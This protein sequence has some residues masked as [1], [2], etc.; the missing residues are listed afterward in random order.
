MA[1]DFETE[2]EFQEQLDWIDDFVREE[3]EPLDLV[4]GGLEFTPLEEPLRSIVDPLKQQVR[5]RGLWACHLGPELG[6]QG[7]RP[8]EAVADERD[9]R[10]V[11]VGPD[12]VRHA[13]H[14]TPATPRSSPTTAPTSRRSAT[15]SRC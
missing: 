10:P 1:W 15:S 14:P 7:L 3:V 4:Y 11:V 2:P 5:D 8:A 9:P 12:R 13:R 6:R